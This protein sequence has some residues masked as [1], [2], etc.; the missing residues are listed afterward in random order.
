M[1]KY[2]EYT[3]MEN[4]EEKKSI[5]KNQEARKEIIKG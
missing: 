2:A 5:R 1:A 3:L 4:S